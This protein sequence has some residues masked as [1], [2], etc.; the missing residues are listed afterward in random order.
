MQTND[1]VTSLT[2]GSVSVTFTKADGTTRVMRATRSPSLIP[3]VKFPAD[4]IDAPVGSV[5]HVYDL[6]KNDWR[7]IAAD[8]VT[9]AVAV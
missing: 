3:A 1:L 5:V 7:S 9:D 8:R 2:A 4:G 6:D